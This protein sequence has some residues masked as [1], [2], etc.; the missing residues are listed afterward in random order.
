LSIVAVVGY[1]CGGIGCG[2]V[3]ENEEK[4]FGKGFDLWQI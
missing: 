2:V 4:G 3:E 1:G